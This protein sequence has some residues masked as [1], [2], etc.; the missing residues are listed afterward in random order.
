MMKSAIIDQ[1]SRKSLRH[2]PKSRIEYT[3]SKQITAVSANSE[4]VNDSFPLLVQV[5]TE[6]LTV[7]IG[8][9]LLLLNLGPSALVVSE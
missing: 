2:S 5:I 9:V 8:F 7:I 6:P 1:I 4:Y 3:T